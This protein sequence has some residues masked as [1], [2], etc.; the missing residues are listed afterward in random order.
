MKY[1][2]QLHHRRSIRL[3]D[4]DYAQAGAYFIT[5]CCQ[6]K[7]HLFGEIQNGEML[8]NEYGKIAH[9]EWLET[10]GIRKNVEL[11]VFVIMP[12]HLHGILILTNRRGECNSPHPRSAIRL[13]MISGSIPT[14]IRAYAIRPYSRR[15]IL[16]GR[17]YAGINLR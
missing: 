5:L 1:D 16:S 3:K 9:N 8:L 14:K 15:Q 11:D 6:D 17:L 2:P 10:P 4:Y 12:N 7:A 13:M